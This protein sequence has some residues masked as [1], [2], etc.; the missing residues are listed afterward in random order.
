MKKD[1]ERIYV[2]HTFYNVYVTLL[3]EYNLPKEKWGQAEI[4][5]ST[6][7]QDFGDLKEHLEKTGMFRQVHT[8]V[9]K[10]DSEFPELAKYRKSHNNVIMHFFSSE[11]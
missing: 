6:L 1:R 9:E 10:R 11:I 4:A 2:C 5:L 7:S 8:F 3:K